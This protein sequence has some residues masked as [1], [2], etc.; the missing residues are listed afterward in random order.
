M[1]PNPAPSSPAVSALPAWPPRPIRGRL[2]GRLALIVTA[3][4]LVL[5]AGPCSAEASKQ[6]ANSP[7]DPIIDT[8]T[9][10][11]IPASNAAN[12]HLSP[13]LSSLVSSPYFRYVK[14][15]LNK[16]CPFW[17]ENPKCMSPDCVVQIMDD[18]DVKTEAPFMYHDVNLGDVTYPPQAGLGMG[19]GARNGGGMLGAGRKVMGGG[20]GGPN[21]SGNGLRSMFTQCEFA[22][23]FCILEDETSPNGAYIDLVD[24][25]E[26]FTGYAGAG[27]NA[28]WSA[29]YNENC[30]NI[31][32]HLA[33]SPTSSLNTLPAGDSN[34]CLEKQTFYRIVSGLHASISVHICS[35]FLNK[36][37]GQWVRNVPCFT[38]R[39]GNFPDRVENIYFV[40]NLLLRA[41]AKVAP[42]L[43]TMD[44]CTGKPDQDEA[45]KVLVADIVKQA[46]SSS[47]DESKLFRDPTIVDEIRTK[48]RNV[49]R[50]M[51]CVACQKCR[52]WGKTQITGLATALKVLFGIDKRVLSGQMSVAKPPLSRWEIVA[53]F[54]TLN[55]FVE[56]VAD[57]RAFREEERKIKVDAASRTSKLNTSAD[58]KPVGTGPADD[59]DLWMWKVIASV[60]TALPFIFGALYGAKQQSAPLA[61][62]SKGSKAQQQQA[63]TSPVSPSRA[64]SNGAPRKLSTRSTS[65]VRSGGR[66]RSPAPDPSSPTRA[67]SSRRQQAHDDASDD[68]DDALDRFV[69]AATAGGQVSD[70]SSGSGSD[71]ELSENG[72]DVDEYSSSGLSQDDE[73]RPAAVRGPLTRA[74]AAAAGAGGN[75]R[76][77][78]SPAPAMAHARQMRKQGGYE[79]S[80]EASETDEVDVNGSGDEQ[81]V[82]GQRGIKGGS[83]GVRR[84]KKK[85]GRT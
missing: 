28:I 44:I 9:C 14:M 73:D 60:L 55:R 82:V 20:F 79:G 37:T 69:H 76:A 6:D 13:L 52:L 62:S 25:P 57:V 18:K 84:R 77:K 16:D 27:A 30:F 43:E 47:F 15:D 39:V 75:A 45:T 1:L 21:A 74:R 36:T 31:P 42:L 66:P 8:S 71:D 56:S 63:P 58:S 12:T 24:N 3:L 65:P 59:Q 22:K 68:T 50:I 41:V 64:H 49:S 81:A 7:L 11:D 35:Q 32:Q 5:V 72:R 53:L 46:Q 33:T 23:D 2:V 10:V 78:A 17:K 19:G 51:D 4:C 26:R 83:S 48:F 70:G 29:I 80:V 34:I 38:Y 40:Q 54:N 67:Q 61:P 85:G